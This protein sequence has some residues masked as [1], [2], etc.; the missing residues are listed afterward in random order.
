MPSL[1]D[2]LE[3]YKDCGLTYGQAEL[4]LTRN[5]PEGVGL[6]TQTARDYLNSSER[7]CGDVIT[8]TEPYV[9]DTSTSTGSST[10][11]NLP[12]NIFGFFMLLGGLR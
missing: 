4:M 7:N 11:F 12:D 9:P 2:V 8:P 6:P 3:A 1:D 10:G 5:P